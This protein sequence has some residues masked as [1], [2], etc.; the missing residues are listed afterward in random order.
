MENTKVSSNKQ[1]KQAI[2]AE[3]TAKVEK[4]KGMVFTDYQ[5]LTHHQLEAIKRAMRKMDAEFVATKNTLLLRALKEGKAKMKEEETFEGPTATLFIYNDV[6]EPIKE[7]AKSIKAV[8]L[9]KIKFG[10]IEGNLVTANQVERLA[11]LPPLNTLRAQ[12]LGQ[13]QSPIAGFHRALH[14]NLQKLVLT[15][16][17]VKEKKQPTA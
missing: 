11:T 16:N 17:A 10:I 3:V 2:V 14:W 9:P 6:V 1:K 15:L 7:L 8:Q 5:G 4:A 12:L 13:L